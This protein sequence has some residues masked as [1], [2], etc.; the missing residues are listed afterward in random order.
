MNDFDFENYVKN[1]IKIAQ[2]ISNVNLDYT[3]DSL[4]DLETV[5]EK[6]NKN[7]D[8]LDEEYLNQLS[9]CFGVY[10][11]EI[12]LQDK[13]KDMKFKWSVNEDIPVIKDESNKYM[14]SPINKIYKNM[15]S[16]KYESN[17]YNTYE[18]LLNVLTEKE[19]KTPVILENTSS[20]KIEKENNNNI[21]DSEK[22]KVDVKITY[23]EYKKIQKH[24]NYRFWKTFIIISVVIFIFFLIVLL[25]PDPMPVSE[26]LVVDLVFIVFTF[27]ILKI[28]DILFRKH[29]Y[30]K[31]FKKDS[32]N[33]KYTLYFFDDYFEKAS[34]TKTEKFNYDKIW[35]LKE[36]DYMLYIL[37]DKKNIIPINKEDFDYSII[38]LIKNKSSIGNKS[39]NNNEDIKDYLKKEKK[40][41]TGMKIFLIILFIL[42]ILC[43]WISLIIDYLLMKV[44]N[45]PN[46]MFFNY[47]WGGLLC[48]PIPI[49][50][51]VLGIIYKRRGLK[52]TKNIVAGII[53]TIIL[54]QESSFS[55]LFNFQADYKEID[56][57][58]DVIKVSL[59][60]NGNF[61]K[62][63]WDESYL[64][65][66]I[67]NYA[68]FTNSSESSKFYS[69][70]KDS[71]FW[72]TKDSINTNLNNFV[73]SSLICESKKEPCYY[74]VYIKEIESY[75]K[76]PDE[77]GKYHVNTMMY[78]PSK[79]TLD[80]EE[81]SYEYKN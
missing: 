8:R 67:S 25:P 57:Y 18:K 44:S 61:T 13:L 36:Y 66:H 17:L 14:V 79:A 4:K 72:I 76:I 27:I 54:I 51:I 47:T 48:L 10:Y 22:L 3:I 64:L 38:S 46:V 15:T 77:S 45:T 42:T 69:D 81:F 59:P 16:D 62:I 20:L 41:Y 6:I 28:F 80:I 19:D 29:R 26:M 12:M 35:K 68:I 34:E 21:V 74:L 56:K 58:R 7:K 60:E 39:I 23:E 49:L 1:A 30:I 5:I 78:D 55:F 31:L 75:N 65:D 2:E 33:I 11:G 70:I 43:L 50:S 73:P 32:G 24:F 71:V 63:K 52:C 9:L 53:I 40:E 37:M